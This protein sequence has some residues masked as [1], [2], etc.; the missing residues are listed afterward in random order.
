MEEVFNSIK[1]HNGSYI[2]VEPTKDSFEK[3][4]NATN[5]SRYL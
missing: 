4:Y 5:N 1:E 2:L 3:L